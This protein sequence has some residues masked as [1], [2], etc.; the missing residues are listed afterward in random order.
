M[1]CFLSMIKRYAILTNV[2]PPQ[3]ISFNITLNRSLFKQKKNFKRALGD[4]KDFNCKQNDEQAYNY[5]PTSQIN[6]FLSFF[7]FFFF[8]M[9][10]FRLFRNPL[11]MGS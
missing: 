6:F 11:F 2:S 1:E 7:F 8:A 4:R 3:I 9:I 10:G 5:A